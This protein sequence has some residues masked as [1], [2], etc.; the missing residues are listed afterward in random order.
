MDAKVINPKTHG[1]VVYSNT[2]S[3]RRCTNYLVKEAKETGEAAVFFGAPGTEPRTADEVV[4]MLDGN[5][6]GLGKEAVK[7]HSLVL[8]PSPD[9]Q[10]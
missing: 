10:R 7:F 3:S 9:E 8:S 1:R 4:A 5:V 2:G 6:K